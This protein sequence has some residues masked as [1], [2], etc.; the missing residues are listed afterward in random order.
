[1]NTAFNA[2]EG[3]TEKISNVSPRLRACLP[4]G[5]GPQISEVT[6]GGS[7]HLASKRDQIKMRD[8]M[9]RWVTPPRRE[10]IVR[11]VRKYI[12]CLHFLIHSIEF[13]ENSLKFKPLP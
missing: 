7:P 10:A 5:E 1:M 8:Y 2:H 13:I 6:C 11:I 12:F 3:F 4:G 9:D